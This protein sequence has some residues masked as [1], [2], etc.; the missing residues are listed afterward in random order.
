LSIDVLAPAILSN[1]HFLTTA[2]PA[3]A[4]LMLMVAHR[5]HG[6]RSLLDARPT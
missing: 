3:H 5:I 2:A 1:N 4:T 6:W